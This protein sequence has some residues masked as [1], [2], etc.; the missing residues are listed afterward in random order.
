LP[1]LSKRPHASDGEGSPA[2]RRP[3]VVIGLTGPRS[4]ESGETREARAPEASPAPRAPSGRPAAPRLEILAEPTLLV[5]RED[6]SHG[7]LEVLTEAEEH[8]S[9]GGS[10]HREESETVDALVRVKREAPPDPFARAMTEAT[11]I[12]YTTEL[13]T[14]DDL[15]IP[16]AGDLKVEPIA[17][18][19]F[20]QGELGAKQGVNVEEETWGQAQDPAQRKSLPH[21]VERRQRFSR[22]VRWAVAGAALMCLAA[23][24]RTTMSSRP[25]SVA[26]EP[27]NAAAAAAV[28][29]APQAVVTP[30]PVKVPETIAVAPEAT[31]VTALK[32]DVPNA[33]EPKAAETPKRPEDPKVE[34]A[35]PVAAV[36]T[37]DKTALQE[38][39][40]C[41]RNLERGKLVDAIAAGERSVA[42]DPQDGEAWLL[43]GA[44]YQE[45]GNRVEALRCYASCLKEGK[46]GPLG[47][48]RS[49]IR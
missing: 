41:Q 30:A 10:P 18:R 14:P 23:L 19:F 44:A 47:E 32:V 42:L 29:A 40:D 6:P 38:K 5:V 20:S 36:A 34:E 1:P 46:R 12:P 24:A 35:K 2:S 15:S 31:S 45:K 17:E 39:N 22:Y 48:C 25:A 43:L 11:S 28:N 33:E 3:Q 27:V 4:E 49:M 7:A 37:G 26:A 13:P 21:V 8:E 9:H 16:P